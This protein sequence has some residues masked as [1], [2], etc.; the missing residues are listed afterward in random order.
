MP[1]LPESVPVVKLDQAIGDSGGTEVPSGAADALALQAL[2]GGHAAGG[3]Q[4]LGVGPVHSVEA[5]NDDLLARLAMAAAAGEGGRQHGE[6]ENRARVFL[7][8]RHRRPVSFRP[9]SPAAAR[10]RWGSNSVVFSKSG[11]PSMCA[12]GSIPKRRRAVGAMSISAGS[13]SSMG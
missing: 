1:W 11:L 5:E 7:A 2:E 10:P 13:S 6:E 9:L 8:H 4:L 12:G 3:D